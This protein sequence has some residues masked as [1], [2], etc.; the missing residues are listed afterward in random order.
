MKNYSKDYIDRACVAEAV[1]LGDV[2]NRA[3]AMKNNNAKQNAKKALVGVENL[4]RLIDL[5]ADS[6]TFDSE[7][8]TKDR[9]FEFI[10]IGTVA[11]QIIFHIRT[12]IVPGRRHLVFG[13][14]CLVGNVSVHG[15][16]S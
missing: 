11:E 15:A 3:Q 2:I 9:D 6:C 8:Y 16:V 14:I 1:R 4:K 7:A 10:N 12:D 5:C 13:E